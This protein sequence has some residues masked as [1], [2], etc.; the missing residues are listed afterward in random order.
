M[1]KGKSSAVF[2]FLPEQEHLSIVLHD[3]FFHEGQNFNYSV[4]SV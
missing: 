2:F 4:S 1:I 3:L